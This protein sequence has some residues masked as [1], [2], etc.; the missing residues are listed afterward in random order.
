MQ[1]FTEMAMLDA[2]EH[3][4]PTF[5][6]RWRGQKYGPYSA[7]VIEKKLSSNEIGL[8]H[9]IF[10]KDRWVTIRD[11]IRRQEAALAVMRQAK[12]EAARQ[13]REE[14]A[15]QAKQRE[16]QRQTELLAEERR[17]NDLME[18]NLRQRRS[19]EIATP[20]SLKSHR[21]GF[22][23]TLGILG[24]FLFGVFGL[25][26]WIMGSSDLREMDSGRMD[27]SGR[28]TTAAGRTLGAAATV[29]WIIGAA[30]FFMSG[31]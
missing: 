26:A 27:P 11:F 23:L 16:E 17:R 6:V 8:L 19:Q 25:F 7:E 13:A 30:V 2:D 9:E 14:E 29:L 12:E 24:L 5:M 18:A 31:N 1:K 3:P 15:R 4:V 28:S 10:Y 21:A 20:T 22:I